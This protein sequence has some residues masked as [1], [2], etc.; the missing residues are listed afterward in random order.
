M[1]QKVDLGQNA[2]IKNEPAGSVPSGSLAAESSAF[3]SNVGIHGENQPSGNVAT[4]L[5]SASNTTSGNAASYDQATGKGDFAQTA[6]S[7]AGAAPTYIAPQ[8]ASESG[9][10]GKNITEG[11]DD[12]GTRDGLKAALAAEPGSKDDPSRRAEL[13][14]QE[15]NEQRTTAAQ[16]KDGGVSNQTK[17]DALNR[18]TSS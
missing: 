12:A 18:E 14:F 6:K 8:Y 4:T 7:N 5:G 2:P 15:T 11:F 1:G 17:Y 3:S 13:Q 16:P 10:H 9:P